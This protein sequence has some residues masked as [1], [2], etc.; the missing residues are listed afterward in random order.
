MYT[1]TLCLFIAVILPMLA[2]GPVAAAMHRLGGYDNKHPR[3]Q[4]SQLTGFGARALAAH[5]NSFEALMMFAP[6]VL[7]AM[8]TGHITSG[9]ETAAIVFVA[10]RVA[11]IVFYLINQDILRSTSWAVGLGCG[12]YILWQVL[13]SL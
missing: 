7:A 11:Y 2:K 13:S 8:A 4:Q 3:A 12:L 10:A 6:C 1:L 5:Q 9:I